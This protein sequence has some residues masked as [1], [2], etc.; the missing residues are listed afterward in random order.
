MKKLIIIAIPIF[1]IYSCG[2]SLPKTPCECSEVRLKM[3]QENDN[4]TIF[5]SKAGKKITEKFDEETKACAVIIRKMGFM[6]KMSLSSTCDA[7][8]KINKL[9]MKVNFRN[10]F[11]V[12]L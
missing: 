3:I 1:S 6:E 12:N 5:K 9:E 10:N 7:Q 4:S 2:K 8:K 11:R